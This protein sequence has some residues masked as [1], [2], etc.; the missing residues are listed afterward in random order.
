MNVS[1]SLM[2]KQI[3]LLFSKSCDKVRRGLNSC[4]KSKISFEWIL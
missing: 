2:R 4:D 3:D 1:I